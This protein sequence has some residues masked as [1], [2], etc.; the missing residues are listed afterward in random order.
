MKIVLLFLVFAIVEFGK[1]VESYRILGVLPMAGKSVNILYNRLMTGLADAGHDVTVI[2]AYE[3]K[4][5]IKNGTFTDIL[6]TGFVERYE[7]MLN[8]FDMFGTPTTSPIWE[9]YKLH[10]LFI[11][12]HNDTFWHPNVQTFLKENH[13][14]DLVIT[15]YLWN[16][17]LLGFAAIYNCPLVVFTSMGGVNPWVNEMVGNPMP[18]SYVPHFHADKG[19]FKDMGFLKRVHNFLYYLYDPIHNYFISWPD[20]SEIVKGVFKNPPDVAAL[21]Y[22][23]SLI[24]L[25]SHSSLRQAV[26]LAPNIV[27]IGGF[28]IEPP[29]KLSKD[30][31]DYLDGA[32]D[33]VIY[34]SMGSHVKS[35]DFSEEKKK[36]FLDV[37]GELKLKVLWKFEDEVLPGKPDNV[38]IRK[39]LPQMDILAHPNIKLFITHG[40]YGSTLET[41]YHGKPALMIPVFGD[42]LSNAQEATHQGYALSIPYNDKNFSNATMSYMINEMLTNAKYTERAR[43]IS[44]IFHDRPMKPL[45]TAI[46]WIEYVIRHKGADHLKLAGRR[47]PWYKFYMVDV[48]VFLISV[49]AAVIY[50]P[51][52]LVKS[53]MRIKDTKVK[54]S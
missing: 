52:R 48:I 20:H 31:Q 23:P 29:K 30:L 43:A 18:I 40:G 38:R 2:G 54:R 24:L 53:L 47:L 6:L 10:K 15:E 36:I 27:E 1:D 21:Y 33:G 39:W 46:Y 44:R 16:D 13:K 45:K 22:S 7:A 50:M 5:K 51:V 32:K 34:F 37:F 35:K 17:S 19:A 49:L 42:Q 12:T 4:R 28:H 25:G 8:A 11:H 3:N 14:F 41:V 9:N 26:P